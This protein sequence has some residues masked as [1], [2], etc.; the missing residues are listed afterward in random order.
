MTSI[1]HITRILVV[2]ALAIGLLFGNFA[3]PSM[4]ATACKRDC[5]QVQVKSACCGATCCEA[6]APRQE[7]TPSDKSRPSNDGP[8]D[9]KATWITI[10]PHIV[11]LF[12]T[13]R[14]ESSL[15]VPVSGSRSLI[16]QHVRLQI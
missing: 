8:K 15:D 14:L 4:G 7:Q 16:T 2:P 9:G 3:T 6:Q 10:S 11:D 13:D 12:R 1:T 5:C